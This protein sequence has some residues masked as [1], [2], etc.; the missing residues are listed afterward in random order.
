MKAKGY[1]SE[2]RKIVNVKDAFVKIDQERKRE[3]EGRIADVQKSAENKKNRRKVQ[4]T[5]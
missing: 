1:V 3:R 5:I 4:L 2:L